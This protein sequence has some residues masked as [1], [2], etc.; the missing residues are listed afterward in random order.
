MRISLLIS[1]TMLALVSIGASNVS[2]TPSSGKR[3]ALV[4]GNGAYRK[5]DALTNPEN[6]ARLIAQ[7]LKETG[8]ELIG[9]GAQLE[10]DK[11]GFDRAVQDFGTELQGAEVALFYYSG[12]GMQ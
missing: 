7:T 9:G 11:A 2:A 8:F 12:H 6:D 5:V 3:V 4:I 10:L 1:L